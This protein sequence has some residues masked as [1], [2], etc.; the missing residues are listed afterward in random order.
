MRVYAP[1][2]DQVVSELDQVAEQRGISRAQLIIK[3]I[4]AYLHQPE[5]STDELDQ[6]RIKLDQAN[7]KLDQLRITLDQKNSE[8]DQLRITLE[9]PSTEASNFKNEL[10]QLKTKYDQSL[11]EA[12]GR[13]EELKGYKSEVTKQKKL[14]EESQA[15]IQ[16]LKDDL[17]KRQSETDQLDKTREEL[18][19]AR[20]EANNLRETI[21]LRNQD[22]S[23]LQGHVAQLT[24]SISQFALKPGEE[25]IKKKGWWQFWRRY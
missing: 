13:W 20:M 3:A 11:V 16:H 18:A 9:Q 17:L 2:E 25:E 14:L 23:F 15:T 21:S 22:V 24:Q 10:E 1:L 7:S 12:T 4:D 8:L 5:P 19:V 6:T